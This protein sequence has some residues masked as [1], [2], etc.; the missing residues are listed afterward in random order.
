LVN[1]LDTV[2]A[3]NHH[4]TLLVEIPSA[5]SGG[6][7]VFDLGCG[8]EWR[9]C[10]STPDTLDVENT[11]WCA[12]YTDCIH[13]V[14]PVTSGVK[15]VMQFDILVE[16]DPG[17]HFYEAHKFMREYNGEYEIDKNIYQI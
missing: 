2:H 6:D 5:H 4:G 16:T 13:R 15:V 10:T 9:W 11:R 3:P 12:F 8:E 14:E 17:L 7:L 1:N